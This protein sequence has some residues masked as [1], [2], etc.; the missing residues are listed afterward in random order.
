M[1]TRGKRICY[2]LFTESLYFFSLWVF[3]AFNPFI[4]IRICRVV[5]T[6][7][8]YTP[9]VIYGIITYYYFAPLFLSAIQFSIFF[10][11]HAARSKTEENTR[12]TF[13]KRALACLTAALIAALLPITA[14]CAVPEDMDSFSEHCFKARNVVGG[15]VVI[16][17]NG[18]TLYSFSYGYKDARRTQA[19]TADTCFRIASVTKLVSAVG[20]MQ[21]FE[22]GRFSL[23]APLSDSLPFSVFNPACPDEAITARQVLS[24]TTGFKQIYHYHP[25]WENLNTI[26]RYFAK[27]TH[28]GAQYLYSNL[29]G[30]L[31]G[32]LIEALSGQSVNAYMTQNVFSPLGINAAYN[33]GLLPDRTDISAQLSKSGGSVMT[34]QKAVDSLES[35]DDTCAPGEHIEYT[36]G[37]LFISANGLS[38]LISMLQ[39]NGEPGGRRILAADTIRLM[40]ADQDKLEGSSVS[41]PG[42]HGLGMVRV[43]GLQG[44]VW[45]GHQGRRDGLSANAYYQKETGLTVVVIANGY[46]YQSIDDVVT[47]ARAFMEKAEE[48]I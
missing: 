35:Y 34:A 40:E 48:F 33:A 19:V 23:D 31:I 20:L 10:I 32:S 28:P 41:C 15:A 24:H 27:N 42:A 7:S 13:F 44:G 22:Q 12:M 39:M 5:F 9:G 21:L 16:T 38:R 14:L 47:I 8:R 29:N 37:G 25:D 46:T 45:Y 2:S 4:N 3:R 11:G 26:N 1:Y 43:T 6:S 17:R 36:V 30:G 18:K